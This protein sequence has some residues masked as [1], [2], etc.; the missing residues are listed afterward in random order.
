MKRKFKSFC[1]PILQS[2]IASILVVVISLGFYLKYVEK[3]KIVCVYRLA[4]NYPLI[5][6]DGN[7][8]AHT[9][10]VYEEV[11]MKDRYHY[12]KTFDNYQEALAYE[13][14]TF[15]ELERMKDTDERAKY[16]VSHFWCGT[17]TTT[18]P[19]DVTDFA[20]RG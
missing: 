10:K 12:N 1:K 13:R 18:V 16:F 20:N 8:T 17:N 2:V 15:D 7:W 4:L 19:S 6:Q 9:I 14:L 3:E 5:I 11:L